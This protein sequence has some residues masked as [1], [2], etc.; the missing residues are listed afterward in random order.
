MFILNTFKLNSQNLIIS[1]LDYDGS[2]SF[3][4]DRLKNELYYYKNRVGFVISRLELS[5]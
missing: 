5:S 1:T 3:T 4:T 2:K